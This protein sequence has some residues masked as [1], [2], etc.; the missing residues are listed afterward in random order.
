MTFCTW[1]SHRYVQELADILV[2]QNRIQGDCGLGIL[3]KP[4]IDERNRE[5]FSIV[6]CNEV[7]CGVRCP[8]DAR[9]DDDNSVQQLAGH[10][11]QGRDLRQQGKLYQKGQQ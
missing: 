9:H 3:E 5:V 4:C 6:Q 10:L 1:A 8:V 2:S 7:I 11:Q